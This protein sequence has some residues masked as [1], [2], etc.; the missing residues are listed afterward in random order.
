MELGLTLLAHGEPEAALQHTE[1]A[2]AMAP[3]IHEGWIGTEQIHRAH[4]QALQ[5][6]DRTKAAGEQTRLADA[7]VEHKA[8]HI[9]DAKQRR[10]YLRFVMRE[11]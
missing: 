6:L 2:V 8:A 11:T 5:A 10:R 3:Q 1:R 9:P 4:A 7:I